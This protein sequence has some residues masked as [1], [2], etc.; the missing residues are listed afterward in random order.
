MGLSFEEFVYE[1]LFFVVKEL[2]LLPA[3]NSKALLWFIEKGGE[4]LEEGGVKLLKEVLQADPI[5][6]GMELISSLA[7]QGGKALSVAKRALSIEG[8]IVS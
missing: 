1:S 4:E 3:K 7:S 2:S 5:R 6:G 8:P